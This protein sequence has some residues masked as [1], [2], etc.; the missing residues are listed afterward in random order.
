M[1]ELWR[2]ELSKHLVNKRFWLVFLSV[3]VLVVISTVFQ[4]KQDKYTVAPM[5]Q[6]D[7]DLYRK[8][9]ISDAEKRL[10]ISIFSESNSAFVTRNVERIIEKYGEC[11]DIIVEET[12]TT[13][14]RV[15]CDSVYENIILFF[16][17]LFCINIV[18]F[19][20]KATGQYT[21]QRTTKYGR[22]HLGG[23]KLPVLML[24]SAG[25]MLAAVTVRLSIIQFA[26]GLGNLQRSIQSVFPESIAH[27]TV[28]ELIVFSVILKM[29]AV[30]S[31]ACLLFWLSQILK[32]GY[33]FVWVVAALGAGMLAAYFFVPENSWLH[34]G[35][36]I[37]I[38]TFLNSTINF[39]R[40][41]NLSVFSYP[42]EYKYCSVFIM[43]CMVAGFGIP[44]VFMYGRRVVSQVQRN[45]DVHIL[46][47][48]HLSAFFHEGYKLIFI[49]GW[50]VLAIALPVGMYVL[51]DDHHKYE[52][53]DDYYESMYCE[54]F[55][56]AWNE[57]C[58]KYLKGEIE[59]AGGIEI[60]ENNP[61][62][63]PQL[64]ALGKII[65]RAGYIRTVENG[66][67]LYEK[68][69]YK[70]LISQNPVLFIKQM[71]LLAIL[72]IISMGAVWYVEVRYDQKRLFRAT[73]HG[74]KRIRLHKSLYAA[75]LSA[76]IFIIAWSKVFAGIFKTYGKLKLSAPAASLEILSGFGSGISIGGV[77]FL[78]F[79]SLFII[80]EVF[81]LVVMRIMGLIFGGTDYE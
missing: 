44:S 50:W 79:L 74:M 80:T 25:G 72:I 63:K 11:D 64:Y 46:K 29:L 12:E 18:V 81:A 22:K 27:M 16:W 45:N 47:G 9:V 2:H 36:E 39:T 32:R 65:K 54:S 15:L 33:A 34:L 78:Q 31:A 10:N 67:M 35:K 73:R 59:K 51:E 57:D 70:L 17:L 62:G 75:L 41:K 60:I 38:W 8:T 24:I 37:N 71:S 66:Y 49:A 48:H 40:Y 55:E 30:I 20:E 68:G 56:N 7:Y 13:G 1:K 77:V 61:L 23:I 53:L 43:L 5:S 58:E 69:Y 42:V 52:S 3:M 21:L 6:Q 26:A 4:L 28:A 19:E 14:V 76:G